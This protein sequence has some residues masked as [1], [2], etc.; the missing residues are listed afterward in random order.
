MKS[1]LEA[2]CDFDVVRLACRRTKSPGRN[3]H[4]I[5][6]A[7][8][9]LAARAGGHRLDSGRCSMPDHRIG[10]LAGREPYGTGGEESGGVAAFR[11]RRPRT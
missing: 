5:Q 2:S 9:Y 10:Q 6:K 3:V 7:R 4:C 1:A 11:R 8:R